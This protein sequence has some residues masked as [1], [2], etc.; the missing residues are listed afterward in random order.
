MNSI[1]PI[2]CMT[3]PPYQPCLK[4]LSTEGNPEHSLNKQMSPEGTSF[5]PPKTSVINSMRPNAL[6]M[7][8]GSKTTAAGKAKLFSFLEWCHWSRCRVGVGCASYVE[9]Q[10]GQKGRGEAGGRHGNGSAGA[11]EVAASEPDH[12]AAPDPLP[13]SAKGDAPA[14]LTYWLAWKITC[15]AMLS[16]GSLCETFQPKLGQV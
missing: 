4:Q 8:P 7:S 15:V 5:Q 10:G 9:H 16:V 12:T 14:F 2:P 1:L 13:H 6:E 11:Q 3:R